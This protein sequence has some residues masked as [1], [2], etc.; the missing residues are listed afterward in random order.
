MFKDIR[1]ICENP[2]E[3]DKEWFPDFAG[4]DWLD[5]CLEAV[6]NYRDESFI[7]QF[8]SPTMIRKMK[9]FVLNNNADKDHY[10]VEH[11]HNSRGYKNVR[12]SLAGQYEVG[13]M[14]P[15]IQVHDADFKGDRTLMLHHIM[16]NGRMLNKETD[17]VLKHVKRLWGY[18]VKL[19]SRLDGTLKKSYST[20]ATPQLKI[21]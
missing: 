20:D 19:E 1:R 2:T 8:L 5:T 16:A 6:Q 15:D 14:L 17:D 7:R 13:N 4:A 11:I 9:L 21:E 12:E 3:E 10:L 18:Q